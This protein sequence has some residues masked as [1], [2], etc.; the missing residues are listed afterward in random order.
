VHFLDKY[1]NEESPD[2][3][4]KIAHGTTTLGFKYQGGVVICVDSRA[5]AGNYVGT[6]LALLQFLFWSAHHGLKKAKQNVSVAIGQEGHRDQPVPAR[7]DGRR[8][9]RLR[10]LGARAGPQMPVLVY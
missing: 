5:T 9:R 3:K 10:V 2:Y 4:I 6:S 1:T 7:H 8:R